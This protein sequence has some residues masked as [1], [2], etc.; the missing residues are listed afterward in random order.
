[1]ADYSITAGNVLKSS[2]GQATDGYAGEA[3]AQSDVLWFD[4]TAGSGGQYKK[5]DA[6]H[7]TT[8]QPGPRFPTHVCLNAAAAA[9]QPIRV[10]AIDPELE[11][12]AVSGL[13]AGDVVILS[14]TAGKMAPVADAAVGARVAVLGVMVTDTKMSFM[15]NVGG[16]KAA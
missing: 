9:G 4:A 5:A 6:N 10:L 15:P 16:V 13:A 3:V 7:A 1:M 12:G 14:T 8:T 11:L 2:K